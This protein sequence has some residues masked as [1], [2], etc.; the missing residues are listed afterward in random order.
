MA[1]SAK[2]TYSAVQMAG[3]FNYEVLLQNTSPAPFSIYSFMFGWQYNVPITGTFP[4]QNIVL[5]SSPPGWTGYLE[6]ADIN[7][8]T[9]FQGSAAASGYIMPGQSAKF[10]F[11]SAT[12]PPAE[13]P[14]GCCFYNNAN[15]WGF[16]FNGTANLVEREHC[17]PCLPCNTFC[18]PCKWLET[19]PPPPWLQE[20]MVALTLTGI[21]S[22]A[23]PELRAGALEL[24]LQQ[25]SIVSAAIKKEIE[26]ARKK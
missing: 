10:V 3:V 11:Q 12:A 13:L 8:G 2:A 18:C 17:K 14:F 25:L 23:A 4:L 7:W 19:Q 9:N 5:I 6:T 21:A 24:A 20:F 16:C 26:A 15:E 22:G 1:T